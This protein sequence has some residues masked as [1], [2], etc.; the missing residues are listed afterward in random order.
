MSVMLAMDVT[1]TA[2]DRGYLQW[3][4][5]NWM[6]LAVP[7]MVFISLLIAWAA[8]KIQAGTAATPGSGDQLDAQ[9][10]SMEGPAGPD[11]PPSGANPEVEI[12]WHLG[13]QVNLAA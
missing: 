9:V 5:Q 12:H 7:I 6:V 10:Q 4:A 13:P 1:T 11:T 8:R 3:L 2:D